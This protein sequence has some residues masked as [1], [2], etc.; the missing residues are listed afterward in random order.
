MY[1]SVIPLAQ[2]RGTVRIQRSS[3]GYTVAIVGNT[4]VETIDYRDG[5]EPRDLK[6]RA[7]AAVQML[8]YWPE[9]RRQFAKERATGAG[10][11]LILPG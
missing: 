11:A 9:Q 2:G 3:D 8:A 6:A 1:L 10:G 5:E 4:R 7:L